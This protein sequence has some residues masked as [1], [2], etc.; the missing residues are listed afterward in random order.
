[1]HRTEAC[2]RDRS[3][4]RATAAA[5]TFAW[6][7]FEWRWCVVGDAC[8]GQ[9]TQTKYVCVCVL[10]RYVCS[11]ARRMCVRGL[12]AWIVCA[13]GMYGRRECVSVQLAAPSGPLGVLLLF[14]VV[15]NLGRRRRSPSPMC[16]QQGVVLLA[17]VPVRHRRGCRA[18]KKHQRSLPAPPQPR[19]CAE[20]STTTT[21]TTKHTDVLVQ[22]RTYDCNG[23]L[24]FLAR[25][26]RQSRT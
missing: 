1:M 16:R 17:H 5:A 22:R 12:C 23:V 14:L 15:L 3:A 7:W 10:A 11:C 4:W 2:G 21:I 19:R 24:P 8:V 13:T 9:C 6:G 18:R 26:V 20:A 25:P